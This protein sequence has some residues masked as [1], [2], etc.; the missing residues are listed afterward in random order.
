LS[1]NVQ[2]APADVAAAVAEQQRDAAR[3]GLIDF[4][5]YVDPPAAK[6][7]AAEHLH[8][9]A[10]VLERVERG[11]TRR[12]II[13]IA[14]R[15]WKSSL[16]S[17]KFPAWW[18]G[19]RPDSSVIVASYALSLAEKFSKS[20]REIVSGDRFK[21]L[22]PGVK[23]KRDSNSAD[24]WALEGGY[25]TS[26]RAV[27]TGG[28]ISG[29]GARLILL[30]DVSDPN[31]TQS[32]TRTDSDWHWYKNVIRTRLEPDGAIVVINNRVGVNDLTG[33]LLDAERNDS[34]DPPGDWE[35]IEIPAMGADGTYLWQD[36][37]GREY[38]EKLQLDPTLWRVQYMQH[39][40]VETGTEIRREWF[41]FVAQLPEGT[42]E[43]CRTID[44]AFSEKK[45]GKSDPDYTASVGSAMAN[46]WLY[47]VDP[48]KWRA[49]LPDVI[50]WIE[51]EKKLKPR[52]RF[53]MAKA[54]GE[55]ISKQFLTRSGIPI[56]DL[57]AETADLRVRLT[58][59]ISFASRGLVKLV[60][61]AAK[62]EAF[63][64][65]A[66]AFPGGKHDDLLASVAGLTQMHGLQVSVPRKIAPEPTI[67]DTSN[68]FTIR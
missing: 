38:Y 66:T 37:F 9:I 23:I 47:L 7:Y 36:R 31:E 3:A 67:F 68:A 21:T 25:R 55:K 16:S 39:P 33:Y 29:H 5:R 53:G 46:G 50:N 28:G 32:H 61:D 10:Q 22:W 52:V 42:T 1:T 44:T 18:L 24:D 12:V 63:L 51:S 65:E 30:D 58:A 14:P 54:A 6:W 8:R 27:G 49:E 56:E 43:Q 40:T 48:R 19:R 17:E 20:V 62:W 34:A 60:G 13:A 11:E 41:E 2:I 26:F 15:H 4:A 35:Y 57:E 45:T 64:S 59:F